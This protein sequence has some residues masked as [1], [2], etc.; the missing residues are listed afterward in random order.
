MSQ[1]N[2]KYNSSHWGGDP[3]TPSAYGRLHILKH[4][5]DIPAQMMTVTDK[6]M[7]T[8]SVPRKNF[9]RKYSH[10]W[11]LKVSPLAIACC[12]LPCL[13]ISG[14]H[15]WCI[16]LLHWSHCTQSPPPGVN[17]G[18][19]QI[20]Q[21]LEVEAIHFFYFSPV[22]LPFPFLHFFF[23]SCDCSLSLF[24]SSFSFSLCS[25]WSHSFFFSSRHSPL[26]R[27]RCTDSG[28]ILKESWVSR[29]TWLGSRGP[30]RPPGG[31]EGQSPSWGPGGNAP[32]RRRNFVI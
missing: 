4:M 11:H 15:V 13:N 17:R 32:W 6:F 12:I 25:C 27:T 22:P 14:T 26:V 28:I 30:Y 2:N 7:F 21:L 18:V 3:P 20:A 31:V 16:H 23:R 5:T 10:K 8:V 9:Q 1:C 24:L 19:K 29:K